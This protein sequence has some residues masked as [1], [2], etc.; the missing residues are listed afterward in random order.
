MARPDKLSGTEMA[1]V[2]EGLRGWHWDEDAQTLN[3]S[4]VFTD[5]NEAWSFMCRTALFAEKIDHHPNWYNVYN[6]VDVSL[7]THDVGGVTALDIQMANA[8][9]RYC[10]Q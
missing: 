7:S 9:E 2:L 10:Q 5:F 8:M 1:T 4:F 6:K 3:K